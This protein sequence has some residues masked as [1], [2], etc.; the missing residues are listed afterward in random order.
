MADGLAERLGLGFAPAWHA[1]RDRIGEF[2]AW[3]SL[4]SGTLGKI[5]QDIA[6]MAQNEVGEVR[7]APALGRPA[8]VAAKGQ[9]G[10]FGKLS[11]WFS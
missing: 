11:E 10:V 9:K 4:V 8:A 5:G 2:A 3:L 6:L 1:Q 7:L